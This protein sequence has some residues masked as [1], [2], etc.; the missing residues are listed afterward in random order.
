MIQD[1]TKRKLDEANLAEQLNELQRWHDATS[2]REGRILDLKH[3]VN[4]ML[5][6]AGQPPRYPSAEENAE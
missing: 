6:K 1:I 2:G 5:A 3:E 4:E